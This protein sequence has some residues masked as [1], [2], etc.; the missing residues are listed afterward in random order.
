MPPGS[1]PNAPTAGSGGAAGAS[2][3]GGSLSPRGCNDLRLNFEPVITIVLLVVDRSGSMFENAYGASPTRWQ[4]VY[5]SLMDATA[6]IVKPLENEVRFGL[7]TYTGN[8]TARVCPVMDKVPPALGNYAAIQQVYSA[9]GTAPAFKA[10]TPTGP[11]PSASAV[12]PT[13]ARRMNAKSAK[14]AIRRS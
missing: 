2:G 4:A 6:G 10:D 8:S 5:D 14:G 3:A 12:T 1:I 9:A 11:A 7:M 13:S